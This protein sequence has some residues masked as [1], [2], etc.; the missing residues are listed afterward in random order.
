MIFV[1]IVLPLLYYNLSNNRKMDIIGTITAHTYTHAYRCN[2]R[3]YIK[4]CGVCLVIW[5]GI[6]GRVNDLKL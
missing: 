6:A 1:V 2:M 3:E 4:T 5:T